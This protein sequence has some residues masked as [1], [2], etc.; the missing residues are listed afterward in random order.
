MY[1]FIT[2]IKLLSSVFFTATIFV[3]ITLSGCDLFQDQAIKQAHDVIQQ[4]K[5]DKT[6]ENWRTSLPQP[7]ECPILHLCMCPAQFIS[8]L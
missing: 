3:G 6:K 5:I 4:Q 2:R 8:P 1:S 7:T